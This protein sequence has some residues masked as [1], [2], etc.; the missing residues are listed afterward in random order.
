MNYKDNTLTSI[1]CGLYLSMYMDRAFYSIMYN[2]T[3][4]YTMNQ[5]MNF[6]ILVILS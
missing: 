3:V 4:A 5:H 2:Y 1:Q 6:V